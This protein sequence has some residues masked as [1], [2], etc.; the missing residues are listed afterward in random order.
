MD[1]RGA[2]RKRT[3]RVPLRALERRGFRSVQVLDMRTIERI[4]SEAVEQVFVRHER[5]VSAGERGTIEHEAKQEF[6]KL[7]AEHKKVLAAKTEAERVR[8]EL[9]KRLAELG[10]ERERQQHA[11][12]RAQ[13]E[14]LSSRDVSISP[15][16]FAEL[17]RRLRHLFDQLMN[18]QQRRSLAEIGPRAL[19]GLSEFERELARMIDELLARERDRYLSEERREHDR[20]VELLERRLA[21]VNR[22]LAETEKRLEQ[23]VKAKSVDPGIASVYD[24]VQGLDASDPAYG[25]KRE[26]LHVIFLENL[27]LQGKP[28]EPEDREPQ[29]SAPEPDDLPPPPPDFA[30]PREDLIME[31][32]F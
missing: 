23:V 24:T 6:L 16:A 18:E 14:Q 25:R 17:E 19:K 3:E 9:E 2:L 21:K 7:L 5:E 15:E 10:R 4:V 29:A 20:R 22:A 30:P 11:L 26:L 27:E 1:I 8:A 13:R 31:T 28:I 12:E 32:A